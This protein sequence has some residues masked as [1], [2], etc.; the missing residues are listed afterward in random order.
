[1][2]MQLICGVSP[3][4]LIEIWQDI[5]CRTPNNGT[6]PF[7]I[8]AESLSSGQ[9]GY[10]YSGLISNVRVVK[11][12]AVYPDGTQFTPSSTPLTNITG[13]VLLCCQSR[14]S[15]TEAAVTP[16]AIQTHGSS[17]SKVAACNFNP[18]DE[19]DT[20]S[21]ESNYCGMIQPST[22]FMK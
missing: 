8:G 3:S 9:A 17:I 19:L 6:K 10:S 4:C 1:M 14:T 11:G 15:T 12:V 13:T 22:E 16:S 20:V 5:I 2:C 21:Q 18:F 7:F